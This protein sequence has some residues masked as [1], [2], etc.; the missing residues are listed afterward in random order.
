MKKFIALKIKVNF[1]FGLSAATGGSI[2]F[3]LTISCF[4][5]SLTIS[6]AVQKVKRVEEINDVI[7]ENV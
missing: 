2:W 3:T 4:L 6:S 1:Y 5:E 7:I